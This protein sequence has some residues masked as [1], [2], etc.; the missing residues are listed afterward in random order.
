MIGVPLISLA[1]VLGTG[2]SRYAVVAFITSTV[3]LGFL[4]TYYGV[5]V[6]PEPERALTQPSNSLLLRAI[7]SERRIEPA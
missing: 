4:D 6:E 1:A 3:M 5:V 2:L 7:G